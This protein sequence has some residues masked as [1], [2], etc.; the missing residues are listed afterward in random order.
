MRL[1]NKVALLEQAIAQR[2]EEI[3]MFKESCNQL[4]FSIG[5]RVNTIRDC[6]LGIVKAELEKELV[7]FRGEHKD[8]KEISW[9]NDKLKELIK[10]SKY[11]QLAN[12][13]D[14][15]FEEFD[16]QLYNKYM[17][18]KPNTIW[19][20]SGYYTMS[21]RDDELNKRLDEFEKKLTKKKG[22]RK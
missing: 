14:D 11:M 8:I 20:N 15:V 10:E 9:Y 16:K 5:S 7:K 18:P 6:V 2:D 12:C 1:R 3:A 22:K 19:I 13:C 4:I 17:I 21:S